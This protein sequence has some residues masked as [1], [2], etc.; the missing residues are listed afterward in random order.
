VPE[1][2]EQPIFPM[3]ADDDINQESG[4]QPT[5]SQAFP[6]ALPSLL[7]SSSSVWEHAPFA[8]NPDCGFSD[9]VMAVVRIYLS[10]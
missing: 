2:A 8:S 4:D 6:D 3:T 9:L 1:N 7:A 10:L 5:V